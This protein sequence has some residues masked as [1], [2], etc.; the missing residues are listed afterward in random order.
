MIISNLLK[1]RY[2]PFQ[3]DNVDDSFIRQIHLTLNFV[4]SQNFSIITEFL[5]WKRNQAVWPIVN[6]S[7]CVCLCYW[8]CQIY[9]Q[10]ENFNRIQAVCKLHTTE[11]LDE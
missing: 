6:L 8:F 7:V 4:V 3:R 11:C 5:R 9:I 1:H 10:S 2:F